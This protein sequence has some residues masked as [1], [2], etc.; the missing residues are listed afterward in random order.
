V[1]LIQKFTLAPS[2]ALAF[3]HALAA[4]ALGFGLIRQNVCV[5]LLG[6]VTVVLSFASVITRNLCLVQFRGELG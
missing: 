4:R 5:V 3:G 2:W 1:Q 6:K